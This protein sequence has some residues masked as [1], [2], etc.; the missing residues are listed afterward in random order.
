MLPLPMWLLRSREQARESAAK[1]NLK[2]LGISVYNYM[3]IHKS[4]PRAPYDSTQDT[5]LHP[6]L[7]LLV[8]YLE[9]PPSWWQWL[10]F[11]KNW[12]DVENNVFAKDYFP[13]LLSP[14]VSC[15]ATVDGYATSHFSINALEFRPDF[16]FAESPDTRVK[17]NNW[18]FVER[19]EVVSARASPCTL[20]DDLLQLT[21]SHEPNDPDVSRRLAV[22]ADGSVRHA[23]FSPCTQSQWKKWH[24]L[25]C[26]NN[27]ICDTSTKTVNLIQH[28]R[29]ET[30]DHIYSLLTT[31]DS[32]EAIF[33][34]SSHNKSDKLSKL[35]IDLRSRSRTQAIY[36]DGTATV[37]FL[38]SINEF[39]LLKVLAVDRISPDAVR[40]LYR[41]RSNLSVLRIRS[42]PA[43]TRDE[44]KNII[45]KDVE[46]R[47]PEE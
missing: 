2:A 42:C 31:K 18:W 1:Y 21:T 4:L 33:M 32:G 3:S 23:W 16:W 37:E 6:E 7:T 41:F 44:L 5:Y 40:L 14:K 39:D 34:K 47:L 46:L 36:A 35:P 17:F 28:D 20:R 12:N 25:A 11:D 27:E 24:T 26:S 8:P 43:E 29:I 13:Q 9:S 38:Q 22:F 30:G 15:M 19:R 45:G 10:R